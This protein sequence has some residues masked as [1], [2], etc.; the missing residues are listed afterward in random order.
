[1][2]F[3]S[4][5]AFEILH[6]VLENSLNIIPHSR[7]DSYCDGVPPELFSRYYLRAWQF[8]SDGDASASGWEGEGKMLRELVAR[9]ECVHRKVLT[10]A[11]V[12]LRILATQP[13]F[14]CLIGW[15]EVT[16]VLSSLNSTD[17][18]CQTPPPVFPLFVINKNWQTEAK[19]IEGHKVFLFLACN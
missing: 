10:Y 17:K 7:S 1:M 19:L 12:L 15:L 14:V 4:F 5:L 16:S 2:I 11:S 6:P 8:I 3:W 9:W 13:C 18:F